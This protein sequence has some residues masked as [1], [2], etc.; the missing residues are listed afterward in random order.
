MFPGAGVNCL[1]ESNGAVLATGRAN[2]NFKSN[3]EAYNTHGI[4]VSSNVNV[5]PTF[6]FYVA[7]QNQMSGS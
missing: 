1:K 7:S 3:F 5:A 4:C 2:G 6:V